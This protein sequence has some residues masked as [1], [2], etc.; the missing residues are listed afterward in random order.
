MNNREKLDAQ[1]LKD[2]L[3]LKNKN[4][5]ACGIPV[6]SDNAHVAHR[7]AKGKVNQKMIRRLKRGH[8]PM[9]YIN[10]PYNFVMVC[11]DPRCN[12]AWNIANKPERVKRLLWIID[13]W[14]E[15][16]QNDVTGMLNSFEG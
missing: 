15:L 2:S 7:I 3:V 14:V 11:T 6:N 10:H 12:D 9:N 16:E 13:M 1:E 4:C 8:D 5:A